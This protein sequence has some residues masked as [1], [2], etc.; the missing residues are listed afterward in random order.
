MEVSPGSG[1]YAVWVQGRQNDPETKGFMAHGLFFYHQLITEPELFYCPGNNNPTLQ[2]GKLPPNPSNRGGGWPSTGRIPDHLGPNQAWVQTT[3]HYRSLWDEKKWR[4]V[5]SALDS[6]GM[7][8][9]ADMFSDPNR[10][11]QYHH[12]DGYNVAYT[13]GHS[14]YVKDLEHEVQEFGGGS[15]YHVDHSR[16]DFVWKNF[17]DK[18]KKY[19]P[20]QNY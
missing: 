4:A 12:K 14:E 5:N 9:M 15:T 18:L 7:A 2:Y 11:I 20:H 19:E 13:D 6:G 10:G 17:F 1:S 16:Q 8:F 3:Y